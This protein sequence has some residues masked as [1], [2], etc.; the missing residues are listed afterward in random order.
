F[1]HLP[2]LFGL[3]LALGLLAIFYLYASNRLAYAHLNGGLFM[4][5]MA[6]QGITEPQNALSL[7][8]SIV[9]QL[10]LG[11]FGVGVGRWVS[12]AEG[13]IAVVTRGEALWPLRLD[14]LNRSAE[15]TTT[16]VAALLLGV[17]LDLPLIPTSI[18]ASMIAV[19]P[20]APAR[21]RKGLDRLL[22][23]FLG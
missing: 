13:S 17:T 5:Y 10:L 3:F 20:D 15:I 16:Q 19:V 1:S 23:V 18:S 8:G 12:G 9:A 4:A 6:I 22:G 21:H 7:A 2:L 14:W 11:L